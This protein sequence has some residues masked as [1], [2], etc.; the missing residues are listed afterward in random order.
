MIYR[1][2][3]FIFRDLGL[4]LAGTARCVLKPS[5][6]RC[7]SEDLEEAS[8]D[9]LLVAIDDQ[10]RSGADVVSPCLN[11]MGVAEGLGVLESISGLEPVAPRRKLCSKKTRCDWWSRPCV[12]YGKAPLALRGL[13]V[14]VELE[15]FVR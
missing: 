11:V 7:R 6:N 12:S 3:L 2:F 10:L 5:G 4:L 8:R 15:G 14:A 13:G 9:A 1:F